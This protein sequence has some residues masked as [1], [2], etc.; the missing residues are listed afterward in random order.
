MTRLN[1]TETTKAGKYSADLLELKS[2]IS[3]TI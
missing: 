2:A 1:S 3:K